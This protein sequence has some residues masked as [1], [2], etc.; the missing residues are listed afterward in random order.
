MAN[1]KDHFEEVAQYEADQTGKTRKRAL[2][3]GGDNNSDNT[4]RCPAK[5]GSKGVTQNMRTKK[6]RTTGEPPPDIYQSRRKFS[7]S[8]EKETHD[9]ST[10]G[11]PLEGPEIAIRESMTDIEQ[12]CT[13]EAAEMFILKRAKTEQVDSSPPVM[14]MKVPYKLATMIQNQISTGLKYRREKHIS[15]PKLDQEL[16]MTRLSQKSVEHRLQGLPKLSGGRTPTP[17]ESPTAERLHREAHE[18]NQKMERIEQKKKTLSRDIELAR[19]AWEG[20]VMVVE[21]N[22]QDIFVRCGLFEDDKAVSVP[23]VAQRVEGM[24]VASKPPIVSRFD[25]KKDSKPLPGE[26]EATTKAANEGELSVGQAIAIVREAEAR[27]EKHEAQ[28]QHDEHRNTF[29][30]GL[31]AARAAAA[32][33]DRPDAPDRLIEEEFSRDYVRAGSKLAEAVTRAEAAH[34]AQLVAAAEAAVSIIGSDD[35][36]EPNFPYDLE[37]YAAVKKQCLDRDAVQEWINAIDASSKPN[38][39]PLGY[40]LHMAEKWKRAAEG[41]DDVSSS[42]E[43]IMPNA[44]VEPCRETS[45]TQDSVLRLA[46]KSKSWHTELYWSFS[47]CAEGK[48]RRRIDDW[49]RRIQ[50]P[51][52]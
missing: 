52:G 5:Q 45:P 48:K 3:C 1:I 44:G 14:L 19:K 2:E 9:N 32:A 33:A 31:L 39:R 51:V 47:D 28:R 34:E 7:S 8:L 40:L 24:K 30:R 22:L 17:H 25:E 23:P 11:S 42:G 13:N 49:T 21:K 6:R 41:D 37:E 10:R 50:Q 26:N 12:L 16:R 20:V 38:L 35:D 29:R 36:R 27:R 4:E 43:D 15:I 46:S 18:I